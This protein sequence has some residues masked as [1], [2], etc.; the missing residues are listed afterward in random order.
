MGLEKSICA[1]PSME[2]R[3]AGCGS[4][5]VEAVYRQQDPLRVPAGFAHVCQQQRWNTEATWKQLTDLSRPWFEADNGAYIYWNRSD[6]SWW[7][8]ESEGAG[9]YIAKADTPHPPSEG[10][11]LLPAAKAPPPA[12]RVDMGL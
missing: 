7:I 8:D 4:A 2:I 10:W 9:V 1:A 3:V 5:S 6:G 12:V 11:A